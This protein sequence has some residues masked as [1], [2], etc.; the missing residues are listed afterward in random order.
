MADAYGLGDLSLLSGA[1]QN[2]ARQVQQAFDNSAAALRR[3]VARYPAVADAYAPQLA[4]NALDNSL[5]QAQT[6]AKLINNNQQLQ[7]VIDASH[8]TA[9]GFEENL[10]QYGGLAGALFKAAPA[11]FGTD[12]T[13]GI[14]KQGILPWAAGKIKSWFT[15]PTT[16]NSYGIGD[17]G[18]VVAI[19]DSS[20]GMYDA[21][22]GQQ[23]PLAQQFN[24]A[25]ESPFGAGLD[26]YTQP[27]AI[28]GWPTTT[29]PY[30]MD[31]WP[32]LG[33]GDTGSDWWSNF[34]TGDADWLSGGGADW[35]SGFDLF[36]G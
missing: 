26:S 6:S 2:T 28:Q 22:T 14:A 36:G 13:S 16:G 21:M 8:H 27:N 25:P 4:H 35:T 18:S 19:R 31:Q 33:G 30:A 12:L 11:L 23:I 5:A 24:Y 17:G 29:N 34:G 1:N 20:G 15:D 3:Q 10:A 32:T 7:N 9:H